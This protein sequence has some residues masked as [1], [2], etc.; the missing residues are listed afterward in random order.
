MLRGEGAPSIQR[1]GSINT[2][3]EEKA[4]L[5]YH[6]QLVVHTYILV[7]RGPRKGCESS[8]DLAHRECKAYLSCV[9]CPTRPNLN[10]LG[11]MQYW[12]CEGA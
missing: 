5:F 4:M 8:A 1:S 10:I 6:K 7:L 11:H 12:V 3:K 2:R 9:D